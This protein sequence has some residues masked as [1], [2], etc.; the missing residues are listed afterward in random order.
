MGKSKSKSAG[1]LLFRLRDRRPQV[2]IGHMGGPYWARKDE[3]GWSIP[4]GEYPADEDP[5]LAA[6]REFEEEI[7][8]P[9]PDGPLL[10]L[11][12]I[13]QSSGKRVVAWAVEGDFDPAD[14]SSNTFSMEW[15]PR[16]GRQAEFP[17]IDRAEWFDLA[18][19]RRKLVRGQVPFLEALEKALV[20]SGRVPESLALFS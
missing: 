15:P 3:A 16:S 9:A 6:R 19:A 14:V 13:R 1:L 11:G 5:L 2:F 8:S 17:E 10:D 20:A 18:T 12:E 7:G 4:K